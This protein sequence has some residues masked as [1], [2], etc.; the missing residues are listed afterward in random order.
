MKPDGKRTSAFFDC[1]DIDIYNDLKIKK[2]DKVKKHIILDNGDKLNYD[3][4]L[5]TNAVAKSSTSKPKIAGIYLNKVH[6][7]KFNNN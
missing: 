2:I 7:L 6:E 4:L 5:I 3:K 1:F